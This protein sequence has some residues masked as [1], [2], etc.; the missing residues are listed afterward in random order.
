MRPPDKRKGPAVEP[1]PSQDTSDGLAADTSLARPWPA[2]PLRLPPAL[3]AALADLEVRIAR[4]EVRVAALETG[5]VVLTIPN[6]CVKA[7]SPSNC[8]CRTRLVHEYHAHHDGRQV[9][10]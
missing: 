8:E 5:T 1:D 7:C 4:L 6:V 9:T 10:P 2:K 3:A